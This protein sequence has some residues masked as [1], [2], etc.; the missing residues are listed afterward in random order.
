[1]LNS[2]QRSATGLKYAQYRV[3]VSGMIANWR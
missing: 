1:M 2:N 3:H